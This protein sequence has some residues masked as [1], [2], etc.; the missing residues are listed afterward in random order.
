M[1]VTYFFSILI[2]LLIFIVISF[3]VLSEPFKSMA[4]T[5]VDVCA[6][7][8][9]GNV[10]KIQS[11]LHKCSEHYEPQPEKEAAST[12]DK[13]KERN[14]NKFEHISQTMTCMKRES[15]FIGYTG[16]LI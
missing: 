8:G 12:A 10:L 9:T 2:K 15:R 5:L 7:A 3:K 14:W 16:R 6:Y 1:N 13:N 11:L 4:V